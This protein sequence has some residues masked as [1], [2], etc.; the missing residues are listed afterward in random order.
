MSRAASSG[1]GRPD[2]STFIAFILMVVFAGGNAVA[3]RFSNFGL[4]PFWGAVLR[5]G[6][7]GLVFWIVIAVRRI[8]LPRGR[9]LTGAILYGLVGVGAAYAFVYWGLLRVP[10]GLGGAILT[11]VP[12]MTLFFAS[13]HGLEIFRWQGLMGALIAAAGVLVGVL[14][15]IGGAA[16]HVPSVLALVV[17][18]ACFAES[19][20][21]YKLIPPSHPVAVNALSQVAGIPVLFILSLLAGEEW[22][23]PTTAN[24]WV[25]LAYLVLIGSVVVFSL[26]LH[27]L[28]RWTAS[29]TSYS[30]LLIPVSTVAIAA[31]LLGE[32]VTTTFIIGAALVLV[33][34]WVGAIQGAPK[35]VDVTCSEM[36]NKAIC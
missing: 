3:V 8:A 4:P 16:I 15:G 29:A 11:L 35:V 14:G 5:M 34:V 13:A 19:G 18:T 6:G 1:A 7:A 17:G 33:G 12:L 30:F 28:S 27:V 32:A 25:A 9:A 22:S 24:T 31:W 26:Y 23:L 21:I 20:V 2:R 36:P 10:A